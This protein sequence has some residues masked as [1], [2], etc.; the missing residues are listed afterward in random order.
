[1]LVTLFLSGSVYAQTIG[2]DT[3]L[4]PVQKQQPE[5]QPNNN[6][7]EE[8]FLIPR[9]MICN[10]IQNIRETLAQNAGQEI[11]MIGENANI[12]QQNGDPFN[13]MVITLNKQT[14]SY[15]VVLIRTVEN[16]GCIVMF[17]PKLQVISK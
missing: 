5:E 10:T 8:A 3:M 11:F 14:S 12:S 15:S 9:T 17:G 16:I 1:M 2:P 7:G 4:P 13:G 6:G